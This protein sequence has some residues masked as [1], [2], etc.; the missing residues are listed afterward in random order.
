MSQVLDVA[1]DKMNAIRLRA[2]AFTLILRLAR[3]LLLAGAM[4]SLWASIRTGHDFEAMGLSLLTFILAFTFQVKTQFRKVSG[5][6]LLLSLDMAH[7]EA[8]TSPY[9]LQ[10]AHMNSEAQSEWLPLLDAEIKEVKQF[11]S[12]R[13]MGL[14]SSLPLPLICFLL[15]SL[16]Q[17]LALSN[18]L[19]KVT[20]VVARLSDGASLKVLSGMPGDETIEPITLAKGKLPKIE[21]LTQNMIEITVVDRPG[22]IPQLNLRKR[23]PGDMVPDSNRDVY[24]SFRLVP[25]KNESNEAQAIY[26]I[27]F[28]LKDDVDIYLST[29]AG[30]QPVATIDIRELPVPKVALEPATRLL[31]PWPDDRPLP[32][33]ISV[34]SENPLKQIRLQIKAEGR[35]STEI[36]SNILVSD[37]TRVTTNYDLVLEAYVQ[38]DL[39]QVEIVAEA[40]DRAVPLPLVGQ[41]QPLLVE[42]ASAYGRY[43]QT[44]Q[45]LRQ[46]KSLVDDAAKN[47]EPSLPNEASDLTDKALKESENSPFFDGLDRVQMSNFN[48]QVEQLK[49][50][51][52]MAELFDLQENLNRF[53]FEHETL[54]DKERDRDFFV[55][56][57][58]LSRLIE[59]DRDR[60]TISTEAVTQRM[61]SFL[62]ERQ[63]RWQ[64]RTNYLPEKPAGWEN[65]KDQPFSKSMDRINEAD[66]KSTPQGQKEALSEL[67]Q[68]VSQYREWL[69]EL[70]Q[71]EE[72]ARQQAEQKRQEGL[73][74]ARNQ[75]KEL[76]K[77]QTEVSQ[78]L[79]KSASRSEQELTTNWPSTRMM[80]NTNIKGTSSLEAQLRSLSPQ[81]GERIKAA[82][83]AMKLTVESGGQQSFSQAESAADMAG[84]LLRQA[85]SAAQKSQREQRRRQRRRR[86]TGDNYYGKRI[87]RGD[88]EIKR[89]YS[90]DRRYREEVLEDISN[91]QNAVGGEEE[92]R[93]LEDYLRHV[94]R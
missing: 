61:K 75:L 59:K 32:L 73:T 87:I 8:R 21:L 56:A 6:E 49:N 79:D 22:I 60:R 68:S 77:R 64:A 18:V 11:E 84:R 51:P 34:S 67:S 7:P 10:N 48:N 52:Q 91:S 29:I 55:A 69:D 43:Q 37:K 23:L 80:Q 31:K 45:T 82:A 1:I 78:R 83:D 41:S 2:L 70:E 26:T 15:A 20:H 36:V 89:E 50:Q 42:T 4:L 93:V 63:K 33:K 5:S 14:L 24:Q 28:S 85:Q 47:Q 35:T 44:L 92:A 94:V 3:A 46:L 16:A 39:S 66:A 17:P 27:A 54:D 38:S 12:R 25:I 30:N 58:S 81:A 72:K 40:I 74:S 13:L 86:V 53:L 19:N 57:R 76:Q 90:V 71:A 9:E 62:A 88:I 65:I